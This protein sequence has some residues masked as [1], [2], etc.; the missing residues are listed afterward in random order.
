MRF[1]LVATG[2][3]HVKRVNLAL[4]F[5]RKFSKKDI[6]VIHARADGINLDGVSE[7]IELTD[8]DDWS[9]IELN[10]FAKTQ[11]YKLVEGPACY[12]DNDVFAVSPEV[13]SIFDH[14]QS[15]V[16]FG[17]D[18]VVTLDYFSTWSVKD[19]TLSQR[20]KDDFCIE[21]DPKWKLWNGG[22]FMY[23]DGCQ[24]F[25]DNWYH[26]TYQAFGSCDWHNRDQGT[27]AA[28]AFFHGLQ[29]HPRLP[30]EY[31]WIVQ[32][33]GLSWNE[34]G[35]VFEDGKFRNG[36]KEIKF[37]HFIS[38]GEGRDAEEYQQALSLLQ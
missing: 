27:L 19:G 6:V 12:I 32:H 8:L 14:L 37:M 30:V 20:I 21:T 23:D 15:P 10:R 2:Q 26:M 34:P 5:L 1:V 38:K 24:S 9:D 33:S 18:H 13:D 35:T 3:E 31:N 11:L 4:Q 36:D 16:T 28:A 25:M 17:T 7:D 29:D 22:V